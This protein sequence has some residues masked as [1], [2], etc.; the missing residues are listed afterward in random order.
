MRATK[1]PTIT[2]RTSLASSWPGLTN[3][4]Q[5]VCKGHRE[6]VV[7][8]HCTRRAGRV[9]DEHRPNPPRRRSLRHRSSVSRSRGAVRS[10]QLVGCQRPSQS[11]PARGISSGAQATGVSGCRPANCPTPIVG[12][13]RSEIATSLIVGGF[14]SRGWP[15]L[16]RPTPSFSRTLDKELKCTRSPG[17]HSTGRSGAA[18]F[19]ASGCSV[20]RQ[21]RNADCDQSLTF[22][23][24]TGRVDVHC[25]ILASQHDASRAGSVSQG[26]RDNNAAHPRSLI[27]GIHP[28]GLRLDRKEERHARSAST[29]SRS[30]RHAIRS[31]RIFHLTMTSTEVARFA[32]TQ[33]HLQ[34]AAV[35][36]R[37]VESDGKVTIEQGP[38]WHSASPDGWVRFGSSI[39]SGYSRTRWAARSSSSR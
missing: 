10:C 6:G 22:V 16:F 32:T 1:F 29:G 4:S 12:G 31:V 5:P 17:L 27:H 20:R 23:I 24:V 36:D 7:S 35:D 25:S 30:H 39:R 37:S 19:A 26:N 33:D 8:E 9:P 11:S 15:D 34:N 13:H 21:T 38:L 3:E 14:Y 18:G 2:A 28:V